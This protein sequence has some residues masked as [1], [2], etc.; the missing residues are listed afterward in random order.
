MLSMSLLATLRSQPFLA[1]KTVVVK[2][3]AVFFMHFFYT[4]CEGF[5]YFELIYIEILFSQKEGE[6]MIRII[7]EEETEIDMLIK[8]IIEVLKKY[9]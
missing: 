7:V 5:G 8:D 9:I 4:F 1:K 3:T 6:E 2:T